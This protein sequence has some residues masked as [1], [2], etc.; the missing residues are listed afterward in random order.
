MRHLYKYFTV[1]VLT[2]VYLIPISLKAGNEDRIGANGANQ[3]L[4]NPWAKSSALGNANTASVTGIESVFGNVSGLAFTEKTEVNFSHTRWLSTSGVGINNVGFAQKLGENGVLGLTVKMFSFGD[5]DQTNEEQPDGEAGT[6]NLQYGTIGVS[7]ARAFS[8]RIFAGFTAKVVSEGLANARATGIAF[9]GGVRYVTGKKKHIKFGIALKNVGPQMRFSGDG[10]SVKETLDEKEFTLQVRSEDFA[11]PSTLS[12]GV[13][14]D[15]Y[16]DERADS[17]GNE[18]ESMHR[19][20]GSANF[21]SNS[22]GRDQVSVGAE[23]AFKEM[24]F[25]RAG[26][27]YE[28]GIW[29][30]AENMNIITGPSFGGGVA[31]PLNKNGSTIDIDYAYRVTSALGGIHSVGLRIN[32]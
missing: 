30:E 23:Y 1:S 8:D 31:V 26:L 9:D 15:Y 5:I 7:Y 22:F 18:I 17:T 24:F 25:L 3:L 2:L 29:D 6:Y 27:V 28:N 16:I 21:L 10:L 20:S 11:M 32:L 4:I 12:I 14:Y 19:L 13:T